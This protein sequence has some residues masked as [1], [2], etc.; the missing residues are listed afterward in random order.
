VPS[1]QDKRR[2]RPLTLNEFHGGR[3]W[4]SKETSV[5]MNGKGNRKGNGRWEMG[6]GRGLLYSHS[7]ALDQRWLAEKRKPYGVMW[8]RG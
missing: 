1:G 4:S 6:D 5:W 8:R 7:H 3:R 2:E